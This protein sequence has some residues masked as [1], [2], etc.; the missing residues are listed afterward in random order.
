MTSSCT[1][2]QVAL[3]VWSPHTDDLPDDIA[4]HLD[5]CGGCMATFDERFAPWIESSPPAIVATGRRSARLLPVIAVAAMG[6]LMV[7]GVTARTGTAGP[8][9]WAMPGESPLTA[10]ELLA[11]PEC[12]ESHD[13]D[14]LVC[15]D[16]SEWL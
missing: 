10:E 13:L 5:E 14:Y 16:S 9:A 2:A 7:P 6:L 8:I 11:V 12:P 4:A 3:S 1:T 15:E